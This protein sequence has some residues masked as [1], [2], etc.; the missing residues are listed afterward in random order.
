MAQVKGHLYHSVL[1][2]YLHGG[3]VAVAKTCDT[4]TIE[5]EGEFYVF[6]HEYRK[7]GRVN[8]CGIVYSNKQLF[9][10]RKGKRS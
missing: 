4:D 5:G 8:F 10:F 2:C 6:G 3:F 1:L 9:D 7:R